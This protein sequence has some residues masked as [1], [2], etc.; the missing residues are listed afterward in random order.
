MTKALPFQ[1]EVNSKTKGI[2]PQP[3]A[4]GM[5]PPVVNEW[6]TV[7]VHLFWPLAPSALRLASNRGY[8][9]NRRLR[10]SGLFAG[11]SNRGKFGWG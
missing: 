5:P 7:L 6:G 1:G 11:L 9:G 8:P 3:L 2:G 4:P 10:S